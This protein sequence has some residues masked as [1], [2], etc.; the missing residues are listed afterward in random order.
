MRTQNTS[1]EAMEFVGKLLADAAASCEPAEQIESIGV[2]SGQLAIKLAPGGDEIHPH[3]LTIQGVIPFPCHLPIFALVDHYAHKFMC[4][5]KRS[6][7][8][9]ENHATSEAIQ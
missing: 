7:Q 3:H 5:R 1:P 9:S 8:E 4:A 2:F 6:R